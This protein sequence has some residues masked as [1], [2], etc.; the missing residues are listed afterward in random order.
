MI[1]QQLI[2][3]LAISYNK[4]LPRVEKNRIITLIIHQY[5]PI[6]H[7]LMTNHSPDENSEIKSLFNYQIMLALDSYDSSKTAKFPT[8][9]FYF[10]KAV[11]RIFS[12]YKVSDLEVHDNAYTM[13]TSK[14]SDF[15]LD[16]NIILLPSERAIFNSL[17]YTRT[18]MTA[19]VKVIYEKMR[20]YIWS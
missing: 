3:K 9:A 20:D 16:S 4:D 14:L 11:N 2:H 1:D 12:K 10:I 18:N 8:Y 6:I 5:K 15:H 7:K 13:D 17:Y 19:K